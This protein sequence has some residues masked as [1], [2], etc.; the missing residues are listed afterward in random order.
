MVGFLTGKKGRDPTEKLQDTRR[1][2]LLKDPVTFKGKKNKS[3]CSRRDN[4][5]AKMRMA[6]D[7]LLQR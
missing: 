3:D 6:C 4:T 2:S 5:A 7:I 1:D